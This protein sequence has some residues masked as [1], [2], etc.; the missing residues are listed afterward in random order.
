[1]QSRG[2]GPKRNKI[3]QFPEST[4]TLRGHDLLLGSLLFLNKSAPSP[5]FRANLYLDYN[6]YTGRL[7]I[8]DQIDKVLIKL[9]SMLMGRETNTKIEVLETDIDID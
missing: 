4:K 1:M 8:P 7:N 9:D 6:I 2:D 3:A 5:R